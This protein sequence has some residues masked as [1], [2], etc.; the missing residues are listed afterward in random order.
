[1]NK[2]HKA[3]TSFAGGP[4]KNARTGVKKTQEKSHVPNKSNANLDKKAHT[5]VVP[6]TIHKAPEP[7]K[8]ATSTNKIEEPEKQEKQPAKVEKEKPQVK[9][10]KPVEKKIEK[11]PTT[12]TTKTHTP[13]ASSVTSS[14]AQSI[15][16]TKKANDEKRDMNKKVELLKKENID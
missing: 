10:E 12:A 13:A 7:V 11:P 16:D 3:Q 1:M 4:S 5:T 8:K 14:S 9:T 6:K 2:N 15:L